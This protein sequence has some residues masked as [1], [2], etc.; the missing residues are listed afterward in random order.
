[1]KT[2]V[3]EFLLKKI[4]KKDYTSATSNEQ[5]LLR[6]TSEFLQRATSPTSNE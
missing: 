3:R 5:T 4:A 1:M 2:P 6:V